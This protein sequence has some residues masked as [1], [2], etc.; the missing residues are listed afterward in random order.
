MATSSTSPLC[1]H[2]TT[3]R[4]LA[5]L[6]RVALDNAL[7]AA[8]VNAARSGRRRPGRRGPSGRTRT[9]T[10]DT[11]QPAAP[12]RAACIQRRLRRQ[13]RHDRPG[14]REPR[15]GRDRGRRGRHRRGAR[16]RRQRHGG[17]RPLHRLPGAPRASASACN[18]RAAPIIRR[19][20][21]NP[22]PR[23][24]PSQTQ[25]SLPVGEVPQIDES[26]ATS[27][28]CSCG[29]AA[30]RLGRGGC[31]LV[32]LHRAGGDAMSGSAPVWR[33]RVPAPERGRTP[34]PDAPTVPRETPGRARLSCGASSPRGPNPRCL[35]LRQVARAA[36][37]DS[38]AAKSDRVSR[39]SCPIR[40]ACPRV[41][42]EVS[43][44]L[45]ATCGPS[46]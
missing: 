29:V 36:M 17:R 15:V 37:I 44:L 11:T 39:Q 38:A 40:V 35:G 30:T 2:Y 7:F 43:R 19:G 27:T 42:G 26:V 24:T 31:G 46:A 6:A 5:S 16:L 10:Y 41:T 13:D 45:F 14:G 4:D 32:R 25:G 12:G 18:P 20:H 33:L 3:A 28:T 21:R 23:A 34:S 9:T 1:A 8:I 22:N